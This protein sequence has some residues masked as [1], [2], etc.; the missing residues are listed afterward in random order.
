MTKFLSIQSST[1]IHLTAPCPPNPLFAPRSP[2]SLNSPTTPTDTST[3]SLP[4]LKGLPLM[5]TGTLYFKG[6]DYSVLQ[7]DSWKRCVDKNTN[8]EFYC[9]FCACNSF[10]CNFYVFWYFTAGRY[11]IQ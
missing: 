6:L 5:W 7:A 9:L 2:A 11:R 10:L 4:P 1:W 3:G 8:V